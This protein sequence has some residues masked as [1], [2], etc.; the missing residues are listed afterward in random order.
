MQASAQRREGSLCRT[1]RR[2]PGA[3]T[4]KSRNGRGSMA[5]PSAAARR[6]CVIGIVPSP[7]SGVAARRGAVSGPVWVYI[8]STWTVGRTSGPDLDRPTAPRHAPRGPAG[9]VP[10]VSPG[11]TA[12]CPRYT[13]GV[14]AGPRP[15]PCGPREA[16]PGVLPAQDR[17]PRR[18]PTTGKCEAA[19]PT[20][21]AAC[22][23]EGGPLDRVHGGGA[24]RRD[25]GRARAWP[26]AAGRSP[27]APAGAPGLAARGGL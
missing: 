14:P 25:L 16:M 15:L 6:R 27:R 11:C 9:V 18:L 8:G 5:S 24:R 17:S 22:L 3:G 7:T 20:P 4:R 21:A 19:F 13:R 26:A 10:R 12:V 2:C 1:Q 23:A